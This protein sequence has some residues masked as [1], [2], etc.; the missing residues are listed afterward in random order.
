M[1]F[2]RKFHLTFFNQIN[3]VVLKILCNFAV[4][5]H[6]DMKNNKRSN[7]RKTTEQFIEKARQVHG[8]KY[9]YSKVE[10]VNSATKVC[11]ICPEHGE[12]WQRPHNHLM[13][14]GCCACAGNLHLTLEEVKIRINENI[15]GTDFEIIDIHF[16]SHDDCH[17]TLKCK[18]CGQVR[19]F[20]KHLVC[21]N[22]KAV[23]KTCEKKKNDL[24]AKCKILKR[25]ERSDYELVDYKFNSYDDCHCTLKCKKCGVIKMNTY[26]SIMHYKQ[27]CKICNYNERYQQALQNA[28][29]YNDTLTFKKECPKDYI[30]I[31]EHKHW[32][33]CEHMERGHG[34]IV[35]CIY[36]YEI[37]IGE[38]KYAYIGL[39]YN[40]KTRHLQHMNADKTDSLWVFC[41]E[42]NVPIPR[43][44]QL[45]DYIEQRIARK[46]E[47]HYVQLYRDK[48]FITINVAKTGGL[49]GGVIRTFDEL[50]TEVEKENYQTRGEWNRKNRRTYQYATKHYS[51]IDGKKV[52]W[53]D[54]LIPDVLDRRKAVIATNISNGKTTFYESIH[55]TERD[56]F[57][58]KTVSRVCLGQSKTHKGHTFRFATEEEIKYYTNSK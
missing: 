36:A 2:I 43:P 6:R 42:N 35:R 24:K 22:R 49:G 48:G 12:F 25:L 28:I 23:C 47:G 50:K 32:G 41:N 1:T 40:L 11:I 5:K 18:K 44:K 13:G 31:R 53:I 45:T 38:K 7:V 16:N 57:S 37:F 46:K 55:A 3:L 34:N 54:I 19:V 39:T 27:V 15:K 21:K 8:D 17:F 10:Y 33:L 29:K 52:K 56:E 51:V 58:F 20:D 30:F 26:Q 14:K 4:K 9:D